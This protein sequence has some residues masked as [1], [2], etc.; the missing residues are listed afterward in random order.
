[1]SNLTFDAET[2]RYWMEGNEIPSVTKIMQKMKLTPYYSASPDSASLMLR[3][4]HVHTCTQYYDEGN[5]HDRSWEPE[6]QAFLNGWKNFRLAFG[7][8]VI[9]IEKKISSNKFRYAGTLDRVF[10]LDSPTG[11][12][13]AVVDIKTGSK[14]SWHSLQLAAY[15][16]AYEEEGF[17]T[18]NLPVRRL[19]VYLKP[20][21]FSVEEFKDSADLI[22]WKAAVTLY[23]WKER[24]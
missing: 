14:S 10:L 19:A 8:E 4:T 22:A 20:D 21:E 7:G 15:Q 18:M 2:H 5:I 17:N 11:K 1:M 6:Y 23:Y 9:E 16:I 24:N 12:E 3:G 13:L